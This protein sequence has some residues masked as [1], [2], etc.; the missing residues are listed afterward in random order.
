MTVSDPAPAAPAA[1][2]SSRAAAAT[3]RRE[4]LVLLVVGLL[5]LALSRVDAYEPATWWMEVFP[6]FLAVP[7]LLLTWRR[8]PLTPLAY[9]L[10]FVHALI[11][12]LGGHYTYARVP[13]GFWV[14]HALDLSRNHYDRLGHFAQ[15]FVPALL[16]R[17]VFLRRT[18]LQRGGWLFFL[19]CCFALA[20]SACY[21]FV[22][23][24]AAVLGG[25]K[26]DAFLGTQGDPWDTQWDMLL[27]LLGAATG[28]LL[29]ARPHDRQ[30]ARVQEQQQVVDVGRS[31]ARRPAGLTPGCIPSRDRADRPPTT[32]AS[33]AA[34]AAREA[35][36]PAAAER[37]DGDGSP[38]S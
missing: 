14:Q 17:E 24:W 15:G 1:P 22:E 5:A 35:A 25:S 30:L 10:I 34:A 38:P 28:Q 37:A 27:A 21:E 16:A 32:G 11:L 8:F 9:R 13:L 23:W 4:P 31:V 2:A 3:S 6:I 33:P 36:P 12:M 20:L 29:L 26:A 7:V 19:V 18:P